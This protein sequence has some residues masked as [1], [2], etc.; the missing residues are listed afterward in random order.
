MKVSDVNTEDVFLLWPQVKD[1]I[2]S[3]IK[4]SNGE[5]TL[6]D[7]YY[8]LSEGYMRLWIVY[9]GSQ[10]IASAVCQISHYPNKIVCWIM[11]VGGKGLEEWKEES[12]A[13]ERWAIE[14]G[15]ESMMMYA[16]KGFEKILQPYGYH[17]TY[18]VI[19]KELTQRSFH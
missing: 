14:N 3:A 6:D 16:R 19:H 8:G 18:T 15:A 4:Q 9:E 11:F 12:A 1:Q 2:E 17:S 10:I 13:I 7:V 5:Y